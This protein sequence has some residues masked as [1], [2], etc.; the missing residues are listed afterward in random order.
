MAISISK[1]KITR[2]KYSDPYENWVSHGGLI[3]AEIIELFLGDNIRMFKC[4]RQISAVIPLHSKGYW[5][6]YQLNY[7][8]NLHLQE[9]ACFNRIGVITIHLYNKKNLSVLSSGVHK[10]DGLTSYLAI[11]YVHN[12]M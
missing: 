1:P 7:R 12:L 9:I 10:E 2:I 8:R 5:P 11:E 6:I 3:H 4:A